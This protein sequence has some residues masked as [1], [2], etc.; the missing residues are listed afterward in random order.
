MNPHEM[1]QMRPVEHA[2]AAA[3]AIRWL[4]HA[5]IHGGYQWPSDVD[6]VVGHLLMLA[7]RLPQALEQASRWLSRQH[8]AGRVGIDDVGAPVAA[9]VAVEAAVTAL[10]VARSQAGEL[11]RDLRRARS[12]TTRMTGV[13]P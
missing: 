1:R 12:L 3:E 7:E 8:E 2:E 9:D 11:A 10:A 6:A 13:E 5:T 4:N